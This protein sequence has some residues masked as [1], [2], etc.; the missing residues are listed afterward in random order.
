MEVVG[1][2]FLRI[3]T[4]NDPSVLHLNKMKNAVVAH[5]LRN[6]LVVYHSH[7]QDHSWLTMA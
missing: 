3:G 5:I 7:L 1:D 6:G 2:T 4:H